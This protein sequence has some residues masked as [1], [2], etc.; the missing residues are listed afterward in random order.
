LFL[1]IHASFHLALA[2]KLSVPSVVSLSTRRQGIEVVRVH[3]SNE[4]VCGAVLIF[5][6]SLLIFLDF[7]FD[8][9][10]GIPLVLPHAFP[11]A[12]LFDCR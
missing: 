10:E 7:S 5:I 8:I 3:I 9:E 12:L 1:C 2:I 4:A 6:L 11:R